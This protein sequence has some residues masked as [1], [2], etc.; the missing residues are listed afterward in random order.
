MCVYACSSLII[1][2]FVFFLVLLLFFFNSPSATE[3]FVLEL[4]T[5]EIV[6]VELPW[7]ARTDRGFSGEADFLSRYFANKG[8]K[9]E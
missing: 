2:Y 5:G 8:K 9:K 4:N 3:R 6:E 1:I 7:V